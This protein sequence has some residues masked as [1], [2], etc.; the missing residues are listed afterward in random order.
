MRPVR[1]PDTSPEA[2]RAQIAVYRR[3]GAERRAAIALQMSEDA[4]Q[5]SAAGIHS[6]HPEY[7]ADE[8]RHALNRLILGDELFKA[9]WPAAPL[10]PP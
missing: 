2:T 6:R 7:G 10:L 8:I 3:M 4:R 1:A 5:I 9:A